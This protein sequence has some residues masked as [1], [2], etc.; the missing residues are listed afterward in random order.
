MATDWAA[1]NLQ[2]IRTLMERSAVYRRALAPLMV[3]AGLGGL[4]T[5]AIGWGMERHFVLIW[6]A[7]CATIQC[8]CLLLVRRQ[9]LGVKEPFWTLPAR[10]V[11][12][13]VLPG[14][15]AGFIAGLAYL[16]SSAKPLPGMGG[17]L[18][19]VFLLA[20]FWLFCHACALHAAGVFMRRGIRLFAW[21]IFCTAVG[22]GIFYC[23]RPARATNVT[24]NLLMGAVFGGLHLLF[25]V[26]LYLTEPRMNET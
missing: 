15:C 14:F 5:A 16:A 22:A 24:A 1:E 17:A 26:Y 7:A 8:V 3:V 4:V 21:I 11:M 12:A 19:P 2:V 25:G 6:M 18:P 9:A 20:V 23:W 13:A 10:R